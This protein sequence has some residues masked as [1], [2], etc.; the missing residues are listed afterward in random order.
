M[1]WSL[2]IGSFMGTAVR[3]HVTFLLLLG[4]IG[5]A[6]YQ[7]G[8]AVAARD[9]VL[10]IVAIFVCV[11]LHEFG[12]ILTARRY[13][14]V[15]PVITLLPIGGVAD[16][17]K[18]PDKP[19]QELLIALAGPAVNL[20][21]A[22]LLI[23]FLGAV[24]VSDGIQISDPSV[25]L[26]KR[27]AAVNIFLAAFNLIPA[28]PMDG[29][30][31][32]RAA[33][34]IWIGKGRATRIAAQIG[35]GFA[36]LLGFLGLFGN[37]LLLF[38]AI[39]VYIAA[40]GE[41]QMT[42]MS[43]AA[44]G[45]KAADAMETRIGVIERSASVR[46]AVDMLLATSQDEFPVVDASRRLSGFLSRANI[47]EALRAAEPGAPIA[48]F[49]RQEPATID[50]RENIDAALPMLTSGEAVGVTDEEGR[51]LGLLTRQSLAEIM[52]IKEVRPDWRFSPRDDRR[53]TVA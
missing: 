16:M 28:F 50:G 47:I 10:F 6:A 43:E 53:P 42:S 4:W 23:L 32:L 35:Q 27:L 12:H 39:F 36:F 7:R 9:S 3:I 31:V 51:F 25:N 26:L 8:G 14:I 17:E 13:G 52:M 22:A 49:V 1:R 33:L 18:M 19:R 40:A 24:D 34:S 44:R 30:R 29:G 45:L 38:I 20:V 15:S 37:P 21:I 48:P 41:A 11:V 2:T 5:F 46:E